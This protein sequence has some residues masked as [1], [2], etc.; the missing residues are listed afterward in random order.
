MAP[1]S[2]M[3]SYAWVEIA[4]ASGVRSVMSWS[5]C[6]GTSDRYGGG[7]FVGE[8]LKPLLQLAPASGQP[9]IVADQ[10]PLTH[11]ADHPV[12]TLLREMPQ[13]SE[14]LGQDTVS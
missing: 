14:L 10:A 7:G 6:S 1:P 5:S 9:S 11:R 3:G 8:L 4:A 13:P 12:E 2:V